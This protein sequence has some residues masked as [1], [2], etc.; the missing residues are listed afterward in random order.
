MHWINN[1]VGLPWVA[2]ARGP[3]A[4]DCWGLVLNVLSE[5]FNIDLPQYLSVKTDD[6]HGMTQALKSGLDR[7][8][9]R[10]VIQPAHGSIACCFII[11]N[12][13]ELMRHVGVYLDIDG[14]GILHSYEKHTC[15][16]DPPKKLQ[17]LFTRI[18]YLC[19]RTS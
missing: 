9:A 19:P 1:Y 12:G 16:F 11:V 14:G 10:P 5:Q 8:L 7:N 17:R 15:A 6:A 13:K 2:Y 18:E 3:D 4:Y